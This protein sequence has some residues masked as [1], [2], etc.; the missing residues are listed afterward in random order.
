MTAQPQVRSQL[1]NVDRQDVFDSFHLENQ[2]LIDQLVDPVGRI[3]TVSVENDW[4]VHLPLHAVVPARQ[5]Q[6]EALIVHGL[7]QPWTKLLMDANRSSD[8]GGR[9]IVVLEHGP[10][11]SRF[12]R[13][14]ASKGAGE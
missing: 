6:R 2:D 11:S 8:H 13:R 7:E 9:E 10:L 1:R 5:L 4:H 3:D 12:R 14:I